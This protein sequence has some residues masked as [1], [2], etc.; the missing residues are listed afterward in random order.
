MK[1]SVPL[2]DKGN[3]MSIDCICAIGKMHLKNNNENIDW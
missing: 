2:V 1:E 3:G